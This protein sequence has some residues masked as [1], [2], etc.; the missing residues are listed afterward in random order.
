MIPEEEIGRK[1]LPACLQVMLLKKEAGRF[2]TLGMD[3]PLIVSAA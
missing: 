2:K 3:K 1:N